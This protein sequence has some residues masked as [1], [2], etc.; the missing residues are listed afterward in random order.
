MLG[1]SYWVETNIGGGETGIHTTSNV[2][3][4]TTNPQSILQVQRYGV[5]TGFVEHTSQVGIKSDIDSFDIASINFLTAEYTLHVGYGTYIQSQK[6][7]V[8]Q[9]GEYAYAQEY[10]VM[11]QPDIVVS[12]GATMTGSTVTLQAT[13]ETGVTGVTTYRFVRGTML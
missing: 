12:F 3:V 9:N 11:Y 6:V 2:G 4:G 10:G 13:P 5:E 7:L 8:M 1:D